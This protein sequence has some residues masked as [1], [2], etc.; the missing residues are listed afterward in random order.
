MQRPSI[1]LYRSPLS[2]IGGLAITGFGQH[3]VKSPVRPRILP[4]FAVVLVERGAGWLQTE[5]TGRLEFSA[6]ALF[7]LFAHRRHTYGPNEHGWDE[8][9][10]LF[11][12]ELV[13][14]F[15]R[16]RLM[17]EEAPLVHLR[18][19][20]EM[21]RLFGSLHTEMLDDTAL[22]Q[23][24]AASTLH[25]IVIR[26]ARQASA[27]EK[28]PIG[29]DMAPVIDALRNRALENLDLADFAA[30][31]G[32]SPATLRRKFLTATGLSPKAYQLRL[33]IDRA[34]ELLATGELSVEAIASTVGIEDAF[35]F[36]R[37]FRD[38]E[39]CSPS[40]FRRRYRRA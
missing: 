21:Q 32:M 4:G 37:L 40:E 19:L 14:N 27:P 26:V 30:Q 9:W 22:G 28:Q 8:R 3:S 10:A 1:A 18:D 2:G 15:I 34:K 16:L 35:Y 12:G 7:W 24:S 36:A 6:P 31:H 20:G 11:N 13:Q 29:T 17:S 33:R 39:D 38:R 5:R 23:A 25:R